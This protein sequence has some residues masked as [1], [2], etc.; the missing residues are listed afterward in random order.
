M[1]IKKS[2][3][4]CLSLIIFIAL[5][6]SSPTIAYS[7]TVNN[8]DA[9]LNLCNAERRAA[10]LDELKAITTLNKAAAIRVQELPVLFSHT[11]P[12]NSEWYTVNPDTMGENLYKSGNVG[13]GTPNEIVRMWMNS[14]SHRE[15]LLDPGF[16]SI[17]IA[18]YVTSDGS[19]YCA[20]EFA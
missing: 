17:G 19:V 5:I 20:A 13:D 2:L 8:A 9:V 3:V 11:R 10:G 4:T 18:Y 1:S 14:E 15:L 16:T 7:K 6:I 12:D